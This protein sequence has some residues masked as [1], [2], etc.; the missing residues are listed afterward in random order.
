MSE[1][2]RVLGAFRR[3]TACDAVVWA[4]EGDR[5]RRI[6]AAAGP[7]L[8]DWTPPRMSGPPLTVDSPAGPAIVAAIPGP[9]RHWL[10]VGP[11]TPPTSPLSD[12]LDLL[13]PIVTLQLQSSL[14]V[15]HAANELAERYEEINLLYTITEILGRS[16]ALEEVAAT[17]LRE[18]CETVGAGRGSL[19]VFDRAAR[20]LHAVAAQG[21]EARSLALIDE[22]DASSVIAH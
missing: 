11:C 16:V 20:V 12:Y 9:H 10:S 7:A 18:V 8:R 13:L 21:V 15:E 3:A 5:L 4:E 1:L 17:I 22:D 6:V 14:E 19:L 2:A